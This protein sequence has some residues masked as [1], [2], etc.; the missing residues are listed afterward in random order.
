MKSIQEI[1]TREVVTQ[2]AWQVWEIDQKTNPT[3]VN[4]HAFA[5]GFWCHYN[6]LAN[7]IAREIKFAAIVPYMK[8]TMDISLCQVT[9]MEYA[10]DG[11]V[12]SFSGVD[13]TSHEIVKQ[14]A[15]M[16][17]KLIDF[18]QTDIAVYAWVNTHIHAEKET[19]KKENEK[20][21]NLLELSEAKPGSSRDIKA[22]RLQRVAFA[23][24]HADT[25][26]E[27]SFTQDGIRE[28]IDSFVRPTLHYNKNTYWKDIW[29][30]IRIAYLKNV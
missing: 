29:K 16:T 11:S 25:I 7:P 19:L 18:T 14:P 20:L 13:L 23:K 12:I 24:Q 21:R 8:K 3:A 1:K 2:E 17:E 4:P 10:A 26:R 30:G 28:W 6:I 22:R 9:D 5:Y 15:M 27:L